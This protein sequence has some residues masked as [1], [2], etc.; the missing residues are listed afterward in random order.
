MFQ[1]GSIFCR[2]CAACPIYVPRKQQPL[3]YRRLSQ[4]QVPAL[5]ALVLVNGAS[6]LCWIAAV[7]LTLEVGGYAIPICERLGVMDQPNARKLHS[8]PTPLFG[9]IALITI[10]FPLGVAATFFTSSPAKANPMLTAALAST[11]IGII[12][13]IDDRHEISPRMRLLVGAAIYGLTSLAAPELRIS[14]INFPSIHIHESLGSPA[15]AIA[16]TSL[17]LVG[18]VNAVNLADG[19][20][21]LVLGLCLIWLLFVFDRSPI[22]DRGMVGAAMAGTIG[23][24]LLNLRGLIFL[25]DG[26]AYGLASLV[27]F[28]VIRSYNLTL[29]SPQFGL[30]AGVVV[31]M[32]LIPVG[33]SFRLMIQRIAQGRSPA[34]PDRNHFHHILQRNC[35]WPGGLL[36]YLA[37]AA[38]L[39]AMA[40]SL[41]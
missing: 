29:Q 13:I 35:G 32:F 5:P 2:H 34:E 3:P 26:G 21:G 7:V 20:N 39:P 19:K 37:I 4:P 28:L 8:Q 41:H 17:C 1:Q 27:G 30:T 16:F 10:I 23:L 14:L 15:I 11:A 33:D 31:L 24:L 25:G 22:E 18:L 36:V 9:G 38:I 40:L 12:G 6:L